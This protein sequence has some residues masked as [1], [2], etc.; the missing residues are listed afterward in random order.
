M[1]GTIVL[2]IENSQG[3]ELKVNDEARKITHGGLES[4]RAAGCGGARSKVQRTWARCH[5]R[6]AHVY[7][8]QA[9][10]SNLWLI[11][12]KVLGGRGK[13]TEQMPEAGR[14]GTD[15]AVAAVSN[16]GSSRVYGRFARAWPR[17][18]RRQ[19]H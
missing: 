11:K 10:Q 1:H 14:D 2:A 9:H 7:V 3:E 15:V 8:T 5:Q 13:R 16:R 17:A 19:R 6:A 4:S 18:E 12:W